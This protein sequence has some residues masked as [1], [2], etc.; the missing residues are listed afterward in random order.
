MPRPSLGDHTLAGTLRRARARVWQTLP[1]GFGSG[2]DNFRGHVDACGGT[3]G[4]EN[5]AA[6]ATA[7]NALSPEDTALLEHL[8][9]AP[10]GACVLPNAQHARQRAGDGSGLLR[11]SCSV[12]AF[13]PDGRGVAA[14]AEARAGNWRVEVRGH[15]CCTRLH[16]TALAS[17][18]ALAFFNPALLTPCKTLLPLLLLFDFFK[19]TCSQVPRESCVIASLFSRL[20]RRCERVRA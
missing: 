1:A 9:R 18:I 6:I 8:Q 19:A 17:A 12:V 3:D 4:A 10:G 5:G 16:V 15:R 14:A 11:G 20:C 2:W 7:A 13:S